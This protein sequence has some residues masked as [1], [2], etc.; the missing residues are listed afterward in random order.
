MLGHL[1]FAGDAQV[2]FTLADERWDVCSGQEYQCDGEV[3]DKRN[4]EARV[5]MELYV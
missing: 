2:N 4:I 1:I 3:L 5:A